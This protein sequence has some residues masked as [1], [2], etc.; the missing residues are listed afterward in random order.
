MKWTKPP[1][2]EVTTRKNISSCEIESQPFVVVR[3]YVPYLLWPR[4]LTLH[5]YK[6]ENQ[7]SLVRL[8]QR[9]VKFVEL[10]CLYIQVQRFCFSFSITF[11]VRCVCNTKLKLLSFNHF[12]WLIDWL[13]DWVSEWVIIETRIIE[14]LCPDLHRKRHYDDMRRVVGLCLSSVCLS[15]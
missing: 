9:F 13:I 12:D 8:H 7:H 10:S 14:L 11:F 3:L 1:R 5:S 15:T 2:R 4:Q 6:M